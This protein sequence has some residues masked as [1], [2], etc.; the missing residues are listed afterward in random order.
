[1]SDSSSRIMYRILLSSVAFLSVASHHDTKS[2][3]QLHLL[4]GWYS[5]YTANL[6]L[7][8]GS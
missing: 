6:I 4:N 2:K 8:S 5:N 7:S 3:Q 1:M